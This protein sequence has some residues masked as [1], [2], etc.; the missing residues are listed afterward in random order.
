MQQCPGGVKA[1]EC[2]GEGGKIES[3]EKAKKKYIHN[4]SINFSLFNCRHCLTKWQ[5]RCVCFGAGVRL[6]M[7]VG[8]G[9]GVVHVFASTSGSFRVAL[10]AWRRLTATPVPICIFNCHSDRPQRSCWICGSSNSNS[11]FPSLSLST[12]LSFSYSLSLSSSYSLI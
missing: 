8:V 10:V 5:L 4:N 12:S 9:V 1:K 2:V 3:W 6:G 11:A 7:G